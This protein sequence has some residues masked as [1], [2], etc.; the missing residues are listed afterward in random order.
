MVAK[1][2]DRRVQLPQFGTHLL[3]ESVQHFPGRAL[4]LGR[5]SLFC[6]CSKKK[7]TDGIGLASRLTI[8][9][10]RLPGLHKAESGKVQPYLTGLRPTQEIYGIEN[11]VMGRRRVGINPVRFNENMTHSLMSRCAGSEDH[12]LSQRH[13]PQRAV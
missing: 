7:F 9:Q 6:P 12:P 1:R 8:S 13:P 3:L 4:L 11:F 10:D 5:D 2:V